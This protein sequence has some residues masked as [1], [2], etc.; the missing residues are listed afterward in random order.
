MPL[1]LASAQKIIAAA[2]EKARE[3]SIR[4]TAVVVDRDG[5]LVALG[6]MDGAMWLTVDIAQA[7]AYT[8]AAFRADGV[9]LTGYPGKPW[10]DSFTLL[11]GGKILPADGGMVIRVDGEFQGAI[12][13][14]G[15]SNEQDRQCSEAGL[16]AIA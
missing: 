8:S 1:D 5:R 2:H 10:F 12:G 13:V 11:Q 9:K 6:R 16:A 3:L 7:M 14:S 15:G 4:V